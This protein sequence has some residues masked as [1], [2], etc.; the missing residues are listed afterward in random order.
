[1]CNEICSGSIDKML[2]LLKTRKYFRRMGL[3][4]ENVYRISSHWTYGFDHLNL[5]TGLWY[6]WHPHIHPTPPWSQYLYIVNPWQVFILNRLAGKYFGRLLSETSPAIDN[7]DNKSNISAR[8]AKKCV[9]YYGA[10][11]SQRFNA[12]KVLI[13]NYCFYQGKLLM[14]MRS[15]NPF[16]MYGINCWQSKLCFEVCDNSFFFRKL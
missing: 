12:D 10:P 15:F 14:S 16:N 9:Q 7:V 4:G 13:M 6:N 11:M 8:N 2:L 3:I 1:M 5:F